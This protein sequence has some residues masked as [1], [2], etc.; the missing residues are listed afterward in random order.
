M[1]IYT[2]YTRNVS[3]VFKVYGICTLR[4][5]VC[6]LRITYNYMKSTNPCS[7][8]A[9]Q[10]KGTA[11]CFELITPKAVYVLITRPLIYLATIEFHSG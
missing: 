5:V 8:E 4:A 10:I 6:A 3:W 1:L 11:L 7:L 2:R 9:I